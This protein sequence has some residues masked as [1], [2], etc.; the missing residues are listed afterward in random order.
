M[1]VDEEPTVN[2][3][4]YIKSSRIEN[5]KRYGR[6][7]LFIIVLL[8]SGF[9]TYYSTRSWHE[10][11]EHNLLSEIILGMVMLF[12][13]GFVWELFIK[14]IGWKFIIKQVHLRNEP[15]CECCDERVEEEHKYCPS[16]GEK[17]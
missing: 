13:I 11:S 10:G 6:Y 14:G 15:T 8:Y 7:L 2:N 12:F 9:V 4:K 16:C 3:S 17:L 5:I 1:N